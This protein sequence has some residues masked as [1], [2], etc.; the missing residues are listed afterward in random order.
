MYKLVHPHPT[1]D[2]DNDRTR[3]KHKSAQD[4]LLCRPRPQ[5][6]IRV[7]RCFTEQ[8]VV[9]VEC[10]GGD[11]PVLLRISLVIGKVASEMS[12]SDVTVVEELGL[13]VL[14]VLV[15]DNLAG[16]QLRNGAPVVRYAEEAIGADL[17]SCARHA[18]VTQLFDL[19]A[20]AVQGHGG[21]ACEGLQRVPSEFGGFLA[22]PALMS[23]HP[24]YL[25]LGLLEEATVHLA[26]AAHRK[27]ASTS[28]SRGP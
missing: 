18:K 2:A 10:V 9:E 19:A 23:T 13:H 25:T 6:I 3:L 24:A 17:V 12:S 1:H 16:R 27:V 5:K 7:L 21:E 14:E 11:V 22:G 28:R 26:R 8:V 4:T 15:A 20:E